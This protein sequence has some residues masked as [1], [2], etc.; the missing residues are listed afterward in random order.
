MKKIFSEHNILV[1]LTTISIVGSLFLYYWYN[2]DGI[3]MDRV[4]KY[5]QGVDPQNLIL[6]KKEYKRGEMVR[7][8]SSFCKTREAYSIVQWSLANNTITIF[9][10]SDRLAMPLGCYPAKQNELFLADLK[11]IPQSTSLGDHYFTAVV[12]RHLSGGRTVTE[13][14][15]TE[16]FNIIK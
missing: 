5:T 7:Y 13:N 4:I 16:E 6:E 3:V 9:S 2:V 1:A 11:E 14:L 10:P 12:T 15:K 8:Y